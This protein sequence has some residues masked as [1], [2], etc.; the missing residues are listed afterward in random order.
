MKGLDCIYQD[1]YAMRPLI[2]YLE[3]LCEE[4]EKVIWR[5][6]FRW[7]DKDGVLSNHFECNGIHSLAEDFGYE[8]V[9]NF[10]HVAVIRSK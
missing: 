3:S 9:A 7:K 2:D 1:Q 6:A 4:G 5:D 8:V 10:N